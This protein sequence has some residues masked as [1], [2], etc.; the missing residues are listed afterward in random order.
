MTSEVEDLILGDWVYCHQHLRPHMTGWC[1]VDI[2]EKVGLGP[3][4]GSADEQYREAVTKCRRMG[5]ELYKDD[6]R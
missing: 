3:M 5:L 4:K 2:G 1:T 6:G